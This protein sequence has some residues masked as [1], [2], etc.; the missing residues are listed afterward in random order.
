MTKFTSDYLDAIAPFDSFE[1]FTGYYSNS[2]G[3]RE[4]ERTIIVI[5]QPHGLRDAL[6]VLLGRYRV[7]VRRSVVSATTTRRDEGQASKVMG[8]TT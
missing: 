8:Q 5:P 1:S 4:G 6:R 3:P 7:D 2:P